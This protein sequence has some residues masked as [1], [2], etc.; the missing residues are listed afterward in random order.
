MDKIT[1]TP[2][3]I[4]FM[5]KTTLCLETNLSPAQLLCRQC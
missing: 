3:T 5:T 4:K 1:E 2:N